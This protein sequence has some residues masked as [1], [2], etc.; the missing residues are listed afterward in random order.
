[1]ART[2]V[3]RYINPRKARWPEA[4]YI[5]GN[6]PFIGMARMRDALGD[7]YTEAL[8]STHSEVSESSD[9]VMYWWNHAAHLVRS[10]SIRRFGFIT[11]NSI[12][13]TFNRRVVEPHLKAKNPLSLVFAVPDHPWVESADGAAVRIAM[14]VATAGLSEGTLNRIVTERAVSPGETAV[15]LDEHHGLIHADLK[16]GANVAG[17]SALAANAKLSSEGM[18]PHG[19]GFMVTPEEAAKLGVRAS[20]RT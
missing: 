1:M 11:T 15:E 12:K 18:K 3:Y 9:L 14:T 6:P 19:M 4:D 8:R 17:A 13:Q 5:V 20:S 2:L 10:G 16:I 7:G